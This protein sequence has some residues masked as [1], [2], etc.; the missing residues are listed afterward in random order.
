MSVIRVHKRNRYVI[1]DKTG[2]EDSRLSFKAKGL[3]AY[4]LSKPDNWEAQIEH[5]K[6]VSK[7]G[8]DSVRTGLKE[9]EDY[10]Y[11]YRA[12][13]KG[14]DGKI[15]YWERN[16]Y[17][18]P[19]LNP[20]HEGEPQTDNPKVDK[21]PETDNPHVEN[22][23]EENPTLMNNDLINNDF[24]EDDEIGEEYEKTFG[25]AIGDN[26]L[27]IIKT[28]LKK[29]SIE[30]IKYAF[31][32]A[33]KN[34]AETFRYIIVLLEDWTSNKLDTVEKVKVYLKG[35]KSEIKV[36][37][38]PLFDSSKYEGS[39]APPEE[40]YFDNIKKMLGKL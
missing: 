2:L 5:L 7:D 25:Q 29:T 40:N 6:T 15:K 8:R 10:G 16:V 27:K 18:T 1:V 39:D 32:I 37:R 26:K 35:A 11:L 22:P 19:E 13:V 30:V 34:G 36:N 20:Y 24:K 4:L 21:K 31:V 17:E 14:E 33:R 12:P 38:P 28:Y 9:L 23:Q 3:L